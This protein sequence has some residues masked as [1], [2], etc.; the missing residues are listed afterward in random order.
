MFILVPT[1]NQ[2][3]HAESLPRKREGASWWR[4]LWRAAGGVAVALQ[5]LVSAPMAA[6]EE[7][8]GYVFIKPISIDLVNANSQGVTF[9]V[10]T[11][12]LSRRIDQRGGELTDFIVDVVY[13]EM[14]PLAMSDPGTFGDGNDSISVPDD[15]RRFWIR[16]WVHSTIPGSVA[17]AL[18]EDIL[19]QQEQINQNDSE[20]DFLLFSSPLR[21]EFLIPRELYFSRIIYFRCWPFIDSVSKTGAACYGHNL[22]GDRLHI[23]FIFQRRHLPLWKDITAKVNALVRILAVS[24]FTDD[25]S[26]SESE[27]Q[28]NSECLMSN[29]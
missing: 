15:K 28:Q 26:L 5:L 20:R 29:N 18:Q 19:D 12:F 24:C 9:S 1:S 13:P 23:E 11:A 17:R 2:A 7:G 3:S 4:G 8:S 14:M 22:L 21:D 6:A 16:I 27:N 25:R 10:P